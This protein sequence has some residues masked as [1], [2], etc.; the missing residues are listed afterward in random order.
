MCPE[1]SV[2]LV[3]FGTCF[4]STMRPFWNPFILEVS[5]SLKDFI[6][7]KHP[8]WEIEVT[9]KNS[10]ECISRLD[11]THDRFCFKCK[12]PFTDLTEHRTTFHAEE[13]MAFYQKIDYKN[14]NEAFSQSSSDCDWTTDD[15]DDLSEY[16]GVYE[17]K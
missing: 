9:R 5:N 2:N 15:D 8:T 1:D 14:F 11:S 10:V 7:S 6:L 13:T 16:P 17:R 4:A 12:T 3:N